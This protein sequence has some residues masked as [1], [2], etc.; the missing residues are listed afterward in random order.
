MKLLEEALKQ[1]EGFRDRIYLDT[2]GNPTGGWGHHFY[3][4][5]KL[6]LECCELLLKQDIAIAVSEYHK[7]PMAFRRHL[8]EASARV[9]VCMIFNMGLKSVMGFNDMWAAIERDDW[10]GAKAAMLDSLWHRDVGT[11]AERLAEIML[12]G[13]WPG[14]KE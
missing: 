7:I 13:V 3:P 9:V 10:P 12:T 2:K 4:G 8:N 6:P 11:R 1:D 14:E 5:S